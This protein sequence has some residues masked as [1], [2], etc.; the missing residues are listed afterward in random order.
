MADHPGGSAATT[1]RTR[2]TRG[3]RPLLPALVGFGVAALIGGVAGGL[4]VQAT[5]SSGSGNGGNQAADADGAAACRASSV[6]DDALPSVVTVR[7]SGQ[8]GGTGSG[9][10]IR[11]GG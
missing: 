9:V 7:A 5:T 11:S 1:E 2:S 6:A 8:G 10:A 4:I 3:R